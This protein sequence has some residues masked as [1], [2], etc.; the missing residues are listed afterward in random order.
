VSLPQEWVC[1]NYL[2]WWGSFVS[3]PFSWLARN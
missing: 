1:A 2:L 3:S